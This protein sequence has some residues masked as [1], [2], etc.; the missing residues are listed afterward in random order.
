ME[1][2]SLCVFFI[3]FS[4]NLFKTIRFEGTQNSVSIIFIKIVF[5][6]YQRSIFLGAVIL[7]L[8]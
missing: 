6:F 1:N 4:A 8:S 2:K 7:D 3:V 5:R